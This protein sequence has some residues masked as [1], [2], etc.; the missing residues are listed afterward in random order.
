MD[1]KALKDRHVVILDP[2]K[3][4]ASQKTAKAL[5]GSAASIKVI[6][7]D[8]TDVGSWIASDPA[9]ARLVTITRE[10]PLFVPAAEAGRS[11]K[12]EPSVSAG[13]TDEEMIADA[14][15]LGLMD[16]A[17]RRKALAKL[18]GISVVYLD[19]QVA[20]A[21]KESA[22]AAF[23]LYDHWR[24]DPHPE[25]VDGNAL[26]S[27]IIKLL[28]RYVIF[29]ED[30]AVVVALWTVLTFLHEDIAIHSPLLLVTSPQPN[31]GKTTLL[32]VVGFLV[33][34]GVSSV[35]ITG[36]ALF[37][38]IEKWSPTFIIDE[39]DTAIINNDDLKEVING[40]WTRGETVIRCD[41]E[42][43]EP[44]PFSIFCPKAVGMVGRKLPPATLSRAIIVAMQ[45]KRPDEVTDDFDYI[46]NEVFSRLRSHIARLA[47]DNVEAL[48]HAE[49][50]MP[51]DFH[52]R[53]RANWKLLLAIADRT[54]YG[55]AAR[56]AALEIE[57][58]AAAAAPA[59]AVQLL[60][61]I[62][63]VFDRLDADRVTTKTLIAELA[64]DEEGPWLSYGKSGKPISDR[65][66]SG[67]L[68][69]FRRGYGIRSR[70]M[71]TD[72][73]ETALKGYYRTDFEDDF[74]AYLPK[75]TFFAATPRQTNEIKDLDP[76]FI[77]DK[78]QMSRQENDAK[79]LENKQCRS[80]ADKNAVSAQGEVFDGRCAQ[81][82]DRDGTEH[83][84][85]IGGKT[86]LL[87]DTC[88]RFY[89]KERQT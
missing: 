87:H 13:K 23:V 18:L 16:Y 61:D 9:G 63:D 43:N 71:R 74:L 53:V 26:V 78:D 52:N 4:D 12:A 27:D 32:K 56:K 80:V 79:P 44:R 88:F 7:L 2:K 21:R 35:S 81:C 54:G 59:L 51:P 64:S 17:K 73:K 89:V 19:Q 30:Q 45:R 36:P 76:N 65:Q 82:G 10:T 46:D 28:G 37:R 33:R 77:R 31:T 68:R 11:G 22:D 66:L 42:T 29:T 15:A 47:T 25:P 49:P 86:I 6:D 69:D 62:R 58:M 5:D 67:L 3:Q 14:A 39:A 38:S 83:S 75:T 85:L 55:E 8:G 57:D 84:R 70:D 72:E 20:K 1:V 24:V 41:P 40:G 60:S 34:R 48:A 50:E